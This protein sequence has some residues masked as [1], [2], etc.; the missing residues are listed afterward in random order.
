MWETQAGKF[1]ASKKVKIYFCLLEFSATKF[2]SCKCHVNNSTNSRYIMMLGRD[3]ITA[4]GLD[5]KFY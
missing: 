1:T 4:L 2:I 5:L 3:L